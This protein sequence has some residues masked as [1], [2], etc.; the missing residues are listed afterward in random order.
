MAQLNV[1]KYGQN[2]NFDHLFARIFAKKVPVFRQQSSVH[3]WIFILLVLTS[4]WPGR[5]HCSVGAYMGEGGRFNEEIF[6]R[7]VQ[8][9]FEGGG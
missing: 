3:Y 9:D 6:I 8:K 4:L 2:L 1:A 5:N 7:G